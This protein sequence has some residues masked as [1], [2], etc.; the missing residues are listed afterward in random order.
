MGITQF[1]IKRPVTIAMFILGMVL[2]GIMAYD[3][4]QVSRLPNITFPVVTIQVG[5]PGASARDAEQLVA[6]PIEQAVNGLAGLQD[7]TSTSTEG[8]ATIRL[9]LAD[10]ADL[11]QAVGEV[12]RIMSSIRSRLPDD[13]D[14]PNVIRAD[15]NAQPIMNISLSGDVSLGQLYT[16]ATERIAPRLQSVEGVAQ[17]NVSG[18]LRPEVQVLVD[19]T[20]LQAYGLTLQ[21]VQTAL[22]QSNLN[23]PGGTVYQGVT[24]FDVRTSASLDSVDQF[25]DIVV[26]SGPAGS[27]YLRDVARVEDTF[28]PQRTMQRFNGQPSVGLSIVQQS[29]AN[30]VQ[31]VELVREELE[32]L[33]PTLPASAEFHVTNDASRFTKA[34]IHAVQTDLLIAVVLCGLVLLVFLHAWRNTVIVLLAIPTSL[35]STF[36]VM[37]LLHFSL[38]TISLMA[39][40]LLVGILVDDSIV[41]LENIHR[42][43][44]LGEEPLLAAVKGRNEIGAAAIAITLT[45]VVVFLPIAF[46]SGSLGQLLREFGLTVVAATLF[47]L[48]ISFT[49]TP[50]LAAHWLKPE[51]FNLRRRDAAARQYLD[52]GRFGEAWDASLDRLARHYQEVLRWALGH[53]LVVLLAGGAA[54]GTAIAFIPLHILG[55]EYTPVEDDNQFNV[56]VQMPPGTSLQGTSEAMTRLEAKLMELPEVRGVFATVGSSGQRA[57]SGSISVQ[58]VDKGQRQRTA[59]EV[60]QDA[61]RIGRTIPGASVS[62]NVPSSLGGG[63]SPIS[64]RILGSDFDTLKEVAAQVSAVVRDTPGATDVRFSDPAGL[65]EVDAVVDWTRMAPLGISASS[66]SGTLRTAVTGSVAGQFD[67][68]DGTQSDVRMKI[69]GADHMTVAHLGALPIYSP[70]AGSSVRLD[71]VARLEQVLGPSQI[72]RASQQRS[73]TLSANVSGRSLGE[74]ARDLET[75]LQQIQLPPGYRVVFTGQVDRLNQTFTSLQQTLMLSALMIYMLLAAL[76]ESLLRPLAIMFSIPLALVG[77]FTGLL[78]SGNTINLFSMIGMILLMAL[79]AKNGI[80]LIDYADTLH[81]R[82]VARR[83]AI[84][85]AGATRLR[86]ILM[87]SFTIV[88]AMIPLALKLG[89]GAESRSPIAVV[90]MGGVIS[91][92]LLT[93]VVVPVAYDLL[94]EALAWGKRAPALMRGAGAPA[95]RLPPRCM[96]A[97]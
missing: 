1:A 13:I 56:Q 31:T 50:M 14:P 72:N 90:L 85:E 62:G 65:P 91:S 32:R 78:V 9:T 64:I 20:K 60:L 6:R 15:I 11:N 33:E 84:L 4:L 95:P 52:L 19:P 89:P 87:T 16:L 77:A 21:Q 67:R 35:I 81:K 53:P 17:V 2:I 18:G 41:V 94:E 73:L 44:Q 68:P 92:M 36:L 96:A 83:E 55:T 10:N 69:E 51:K 57:D 70:V 12:D 58:L 23:S 39:L 24:Q 30:A 49:L 71:Q 79:V 97:A 42:H 22:S 46:I 34:S 38:N 86:P 75:Q 61:R 28:A 74:V 37:Y 27:V 82:G 47:S 7:I 80:L 25:R 76:Y 66:V 40:A 3:R 8:R 63:G 93:L 43:R 54:L 48:F 88:F 45:D 26:S 29:G 5:Y 59:T